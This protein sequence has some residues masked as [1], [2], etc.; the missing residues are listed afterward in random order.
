MSNLFTAARLPF[1]VAVGTAVGSAVGAE[2]SPRLQSAINDAWRAHQDKPPGYTT[3]AAG[4]AQGQVEP[5]WAAARASEQGISGDAFGRLV[6]IANVGPGATFAFEMWRR[7]FITDSGFATAL[8]RLAIEDQWLA[9]LRELKNILLSPAEV[10]NA[11]Q[12]GH[13]PNDGILPNVS[14]GT[15]PAQGYVVPPAP[16]ERPPS[17]VPLT[18]INIDPLSEAAGS[19]V[20]QERLQVMANLAGLPPG[21]EALLTMWNRQLIDESSVD[22]GIREGHMK[23]KWAGAF[24]RMRWAVLSAQDYASAH[25]RQ[26]V[27]QE[28][29]YEGG[30]LTGHTKDQ[31]DL[32][33][34]NRGRPASPTQMWRAWARGVIG[35]RG[36][37]TDYADHAKAIAISDIRPEY[38]EML[39]GIRFN[40]PTLF[41]LNRLVQAGAIDVATG[42]D[43]AHKSLYAPEVV[44]ALTDYWSQPAQGTTSSWPGRAATQLWTATH[45]AY[46]K[47]DL[48]DDLARSTL[49]FIPVR[50]ADLDAV[51]L[52][53]D[54]ERSVTRADLTPAEIRREYRKGV[55]TQAEA[56]AELEA[57]GYTLDDANRYLS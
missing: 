13:L 56:M 34:L 26:W 45:R 36:V 11:V 10:A 43:W 50:G 55:I 22:A 9:P 19:G 39:W 17:T 16:D 53:W 47:G 41:Q 54:A 48:P 37:P 57:R 1:S 8:K 51:M 32:L 14:A 42:A 29:M 24:K 23:T 20:T 3:L 31:M 35:P 46:I 7:G 30:A 28:Q 40:Y 44:T 21:P 2:I 25:L 38:A 33:F 49:G 12:Q 6:E 52:L 27:D 5:T 4:V 15:T 18:Q